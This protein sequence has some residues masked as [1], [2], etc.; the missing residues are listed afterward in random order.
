MTIDPRA[1]GKQ[2]GSCTLCCKLLGISALG[3][4][5]DQ[6][7]SH[8][9][10][11]RGCRIYD[12]RPQACAEFFCLFLM[13]G[14][15][16]EAWRP[17]NSKIVLTADADHN[18]IVANV[19]PDRPRAWRRDPFYKTLK[20]WS[21][22]ARPQNGRVVV[23]I[24]RKMIVIFPDKDVDL[25]IVA[26]DE[27][28]CIKQTPTDGGIV[29]DAFKMKRDD[30]RARFESVVRESGGAPEFQAQLRDRLSAR[31]SGP[32]AAPGPRQM[33]RNN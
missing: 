27:V 16:G 33:S 29:C 6:W 18:S 13:H 26:D 22:A 9:E 4:P 24:G 17:S 14:G 5:M 7:C 12:K 10:I 28:I 15:L 32:N 30:P 8:C 21:I 3:K 25:G 23:R 2:C 19:D 31:W 11:G 1:P 20:E